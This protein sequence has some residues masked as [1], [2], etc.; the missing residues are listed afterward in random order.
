MTDS[1]IRVGLLQGRSVLR[2]AN[3]NRRE[4]RTHHKWRA[5]KFRVGRGCL[6]VLSEAEGSRCDV[7]YTA[8]LFRQVL[9]GV[10]AKRSTEA[11]PD[12]LPHE[13]EVT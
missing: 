3:R 6:L 11:S 8:F 5:T 2:P 12:G 9:A 13:D 1:L 4:R 10:A 7:A